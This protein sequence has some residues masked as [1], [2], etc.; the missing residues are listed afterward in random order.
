MPPSK[1]VDLSPDD[2]DILEA[3][4]LMFERECVAEIASLSG[5]EGYVY[6]FELDH[7]LIES[8]PVLSYH[9]H[10]SPA[11]TLEFGTQVLSEKFTAA[12][13]AP[14]PNIRVMNLH[15]RYLKRVDEL[16]MR[17]RNDVVMLDVKIEDITHPH[18]WLKKAIYECRDCKTVTHID[19]RRARERDSP[20]VCRICLEK[21]FEG[22]ETHGMPMS[23]FYPRPNFKMLN[24]ICKYEDIQGF[25][26]RQITYD[27]EHHL[28]NC[29]TKNEISGVVT[30]DMVGELNASS[31]ARVNGVL[32]V[33][34]LPTRNFAK[35][36]RRLLSLDVF[37]IEPLP[38]EEAGQS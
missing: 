1:P 5:L 8:D 19:Q 38:I 37:S 16:R 36:T 14:R 31:Y 12:G 4:R 21:A 18:G 23:M 17:D 11:N 34:P 3:W 24:E 20:R 28:I 7:G 30:D 2:Q 22:I 35:D 13:I 33:D 25:S 32:R 29:S 10:T 9:F 6:G 15:P 26:M 27:G